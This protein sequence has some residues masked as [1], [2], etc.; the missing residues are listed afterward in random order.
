MNQVHC[1]FYFILTLYLIVSLDN[2]QNIQIK[3]DIINFLQLI[4]KLC[5]LE[6]LVNEI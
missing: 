2:F 3:Y 4:H 1:N 6:N 5:N